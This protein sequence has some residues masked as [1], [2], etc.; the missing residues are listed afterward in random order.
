MTTTT[1]KEKTVT[2]PT[3]TAPIPT[4]APATVPAAEPTAVELFF[5]LSERMRQ[6]AKEIGP[7]RVTL[8]GVSVTGEWPET[9]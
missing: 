4:A 6:A 5:E 8:A 3:T 7:V 2:K 1:S 9:H